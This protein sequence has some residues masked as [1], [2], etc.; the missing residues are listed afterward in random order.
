MTDLWASER[1]SDWAAALAN[2]DVQLNRQGSELLLKRDPWYR[3]ELVPL[4]AE[5]AEPFLSRDELVWIVE[6]KMARGVWR[7]RNLHLARSNSSAEVEQ[8]SRAAFAAVPDARAPLRLLSTLKGVGPA[9]ASAA[10]AAFRPDLYPFFDDVVAAQ[11]PGQ[12]SDEFTLKAY[13]TYADAL[14]RRAEALTATCG[15]DWTAQSVGLALWA[16]AGGKA[17]EHPSCSPSR[18]T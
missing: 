4:L 10:L 8:A 16:V 12:V 7:A 6:W 17:G 18:P 3:H 14:R 15:S 11:I 1:C 13:L 2:Y 9:T 5:R